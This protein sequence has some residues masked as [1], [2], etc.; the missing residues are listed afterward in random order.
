MEEAEELEVELMEMRTRVLKEERPQMQTNTLIS[1][2]NLAEK[3]MNQER[4]KEAEEL[5]L[6]TMETNLKILGQEHPE[7]LTSMAYLT[8]ER[9]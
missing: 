9:G 1:V 4:W 5:G 8:M 2:A 6:L 3:Y 7:T